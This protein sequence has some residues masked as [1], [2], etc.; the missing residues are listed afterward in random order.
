MSMSASDVTEVSSLIEAWSAILAKWLVAYKAVANAV[1][2]P[3]KAEDRAVVIIGSI[4]LL[5]VILDLENIMVKTKMD[6][7][8][9]ITMSKISS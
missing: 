4:S 6:E 8:C 3:V 7:P 9:I 1:I 2:G 5:D